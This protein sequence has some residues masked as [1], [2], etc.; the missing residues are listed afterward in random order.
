MH[1]RFHD[2]VNGEADAAIGFYESDPSSAGDRFEAELRRII[3]SIRTWPELGSPTLGRAR[4]R[5]LQ[6]FPYSVIY[7]VK[8]DHVYIIAIAH[9]KQQW[10]YWRNR[11]E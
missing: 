8:S 10:G 9:F 7:Q 4:R 3:A 5:I 1:V 6:G 11:L 2:E